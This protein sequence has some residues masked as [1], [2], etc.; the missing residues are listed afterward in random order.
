MLWGI[1]WPIWSFLGIT[2]LLILIVTYVLEL[3]YR[4]NQS[5]GV[6]AEQDRKLKALAIRRHTRELRR[7]TLDI[8]NLKYEL[9]QDRRKAAEQQDPAWGGWDMKPPGFKE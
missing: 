3:L 9:Y 6:D 7:I 2:M 1:A 5:R 8:N 4:I